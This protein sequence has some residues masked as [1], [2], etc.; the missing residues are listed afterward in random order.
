M[1]TKK[2]KELS[3]IASTGKLKGSIPSGFKSGDSAN[4]LMVVEPLIKHPEVDGL[5]RAVDPQTGWK[6]WVEYTPPAPVVMPPVI[7]PEQEKHNQYSEKLEQLK[8]KSGLVSLGV[9]QDSD[10]MLLRQ[11]VK[12]LATQLGI[13]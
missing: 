1:P 2:L 13:I 7:T 9:I 10:L 3:E 12:N 5:Y 8:M 6:G 4:E 11:E